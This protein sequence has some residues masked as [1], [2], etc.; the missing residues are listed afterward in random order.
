MQVHPQLYS[1]TPWAGTFCTPGG[2]AAPLPGNPANSP[3]HGRASQAATRAK[4]KAAKKKLAEAQAASDA[5]DAEA[6]ASARMNH[7]PIYNNSPYTYPSTLYP[8][9][10]YGTPATV[11]SYLD[12]VTGAAMPYTPSAPP[13]IVLNNP[14]GCSVYGGG[15]TYTTP[16][17]AYLGLSP[18]PPMYQEL[19]EA[20]E[21]PFNKWEAG[22]NGHL[23]DNRASPVSLNSITSKLDV[24]PILSHDAG[25]PLIMDLSLLREDISTLEEPGESWWD[26]AKSVRSQP[27]C[28][29][30]VTRL[31]LVSPKAKY[32][33]EVVNA[34]GVTASRFGSC[35]VHFMLIVVSVHTGRRCDRQLVAKLP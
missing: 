5:A 30:R 10:P 1:G 28:I 31:R 26:D 20:S 23:Y 21:V 27:A 24:N 3:Y 34:L 29:P 14:V 25:F 11:Y 12:P 16:A 6:K 19:G 22:K 18:V 35:S 17:P 8:A 7:V 32:P 33:I 2:Y 4:A 9:Q 13:N 15:G